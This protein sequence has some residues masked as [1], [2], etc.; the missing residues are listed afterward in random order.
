LPKF[1]G[2]DIRSAPMAKYPRI[3]APFCVKCGSGRQA[4]APRG[5]RSGLFSLR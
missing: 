5:M 3:R 4:P 2:F 1:K